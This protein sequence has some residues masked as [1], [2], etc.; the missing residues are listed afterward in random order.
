MTRMLACCAILVAAC[1]PPEPAKKV[2][3]PKAAPAEVKDLATPEE[4]HL[5]NLHQLTFGGDN[6]EA[7]WSFAG[8]RLIMQT[9]HKPYQCDQIEEMP[10]TGIGGGNGKLVS[11]GK[12]RTTC[13]YFL[14]G[15]QEIIYASTHANGP[16]CPTPP[17]M[18]KGYNWGLFEYDIYR[19]NADGTNLRRLTDTP[20]YDAEAT[21]CPVDGSIIFTSMRSGDLEL[22]RMDADGKNPKQITSTPGY[23]GGAFYSADCK[24]IVWRASRPQGEELEKYNALLKQNLVKPTK[25]DLWV[26][27]ADG[28]EARQ[29]TYLPGAS[30][31]PYFYPSGK[32]V[33]FASNYLA[34]TG[35]EFDLFAINTD[36]TDLERITYAGGFDGFPMFS[37][38][39]KWLSFSSNR[40]DVVKQGDKEVYRMT[41]GVAGI[42]D[43]NV[44]LAEWND[45]PATTK[46]QPETDAANRFR[47]A[48]RYL[49]DDAREGRGIGT[50]GLADA[51]DYVEKRFAEAGVEPGLAGAWRQPFEVT[52]SV[53]RGGK[54]ALAL[55]GKTIAIEDFAPIAASGSGAASGAIVAVGWGIVD[56]D[57][58][59]DDYKGKDVKGKIALVH[60]FAP[61]GLSGS[62]T[63]RLGDLR[64]K[65]FIARGKGATALLVVDDG[66]PKQEEAPL[67]KLAAAESEAGIPV[68][69]VTRKAWGKGAKSTKLAAELVPVRAKTENVV[70]VIRAGAAQKQ[71]GILVIGAHVDHLG[72]GGGSNALDPTVNAVHNGADDNASGVAGLLE[73]ARVL[74]AKKSEL[75]R[76]VYVVAFSGEEEGDLGSDYFVK[77]LPVPEVDRAKNKSPVFAMLNMDMIGRMRGDKLSVSGGDSAKQWKELVAPACK[78]AH[79]DC[80]IGGSGYGPSDHMAFYVT[81]VPVLF[82]FTGSHLDYHTATDDSDKIN[83][84]GGARVAMIAADVALASGKLAALD[85]VKAP[86]E[87]VFGGDVR[88]K[89]ASLGTV[90]S[91]DEDPS[92][93]PGVLLSD[94]VPEGAAAKAGLKGG[95]RIVRIGVTEI[96]NVEDLMFVL[97]TS[98]PGT[99]VT[100][101]FVRGGKTETAT[102]TFGVPRGRR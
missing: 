13:S 36:G 85:Y 72:M 17:D 38:D 88:R 78:T 45:H 98:K 10:L 62:E 26:A 33:I 50:K 90:P 20:G 51:E 35:P 23:D 87:M 64:Y 82:F 83:S 19:A 52:T 24:Q 22:W 40:R 66:D 32:R 73:V 93:P 37:P 102:A 75:T 5:V 67:P 46:Y 91:Y 100:I 70:G 18:S 60:R 79:V 84:T 89:G 99:D 14:K 27:N 1:C 96:R 42:H 69:V 30:F 54:T 34:P 77:H 56:G 53:T 76:D 9:N 41:G 29:I 63:S 86:P 3:A 31:G 74:G 8:D 95:D 58:K 80:T 61:A 71:A 2:V 43:T 59:L 15:D 16:D 47:D 11:T 57:A 55:D 4:T 97:E 12:G 44:F 6:A 48:V 7:Y 81:G 68:I 65:A 101:T 49:A 92:R 94:V 39:G 28:T 25:M 21:V